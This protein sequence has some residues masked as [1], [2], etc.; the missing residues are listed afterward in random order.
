MNA[1]KSNITKDDTFG[2]CTL[3]LIGDH[4]QLPPI[5]DLPLHNSNT[6]KMNASNK[7]GYIFSKAIDDVVILGNN[8]RQKKDMQFQK[9]LQECRLGILSEKHYQMFKKRIVGS[10]LKGLKNVLCLFG[11]ND[12]VERFNALFQKTRIIMNNRFYGDDKNLTYNIQAIDCKVDSDQELTLTE[13]KDL[14]KKHPNATGSLLGILTLTVGDIVSLRKNIDHRFGLVTNSRGTVVGFGL[15]NN[16]VE[17]IYVKMFKLLNR[18]GLGDEMYGKNVVP[19]VRYEQLFKYRAKSNYDKEGQI[20]RKQFPLALNYANTVH[21]VQSLTHTGI[22]LLDVKSCNFNSRLFYTA[23]TRSDK[24][25]NIIILRDFEKKNISK[26]PS[27]DLISFDESLQ[28]R[29][30]NTIIKYRF[31]LPIGFDLTA[32]STWNNIEK[33]LNHTYKVTKI[34]TNIEYDISVTKI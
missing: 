9:M 2:N 25:E 11:K 27:K 23:V 29:Y 5:N 34:F 16:A 8:F 32:I 22:L 15:L 4:Y 21:S 3:V 24:L 18:S 7:N 1:I 12:H 28:A 30:I 13:R 6:N 26:T 10:T 33:Y 19:I 17:V 14:F 31:L 20:Q